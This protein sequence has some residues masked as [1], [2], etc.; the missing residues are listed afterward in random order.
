[1]TSHW[2]FMMFGFVIIK[3]QL[4]FSEQLIYIQLVDLLSPVKNE[5]ESIHWSD[6][7]IEVKTEACT[8]SG[9][10]KPSRGCIQT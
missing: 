3:L 1:M 6:G 2:A 7:L 4:A 8:I 5:M 10:P 9:P